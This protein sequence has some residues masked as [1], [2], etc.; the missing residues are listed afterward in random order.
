MIQRYTYR[1]RLCH[2]I[3]SAFYVY[4]LATGLAFFTPYLYW[5]AIALGGGPT[6]RFWHPI[7]GIAFFL[8]QMWMHRLWSA[9]MHITPVDREWLDKSKEYATNHD[10]NVPPQHR[11][12]AGQKIFYWEMYVGAFFLLLSG[13]AMWFPE[14]LPWVGRATAILI[15]EIAALVTIGAFIIHVYMGVFVVPGSVKAMTE[16]EVSEAWAKTHHRLWYDRV[17]K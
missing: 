13:I 11:F 9:D 2:W 8:A 3:T 15:H 10:E 17:R 4:C 6:S 14:Y 12:N 16:G 5:I 1:E 7:V